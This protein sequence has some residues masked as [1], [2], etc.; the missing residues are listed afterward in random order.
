[1]GIKKDLEEGLA[2]FLVCVVGHVQS[3][4]LLF[5]PSQ[6]LNE[7]LGDFQLPGT[8][9]NA[10][11]YMHKRLHYHRLYVLESYVTNACRRIAFLLYP[12]VIKER[13]KY[14]VGRVE[15]SAA[16]AACERG[17]S[18]VNTCRPSFP[19]FDT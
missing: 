9:Y 17:H 14:N 18:Q 2:N 16:A 7:R 5:I 11:V 3:R 15:P 10:L 1:M 13:K 19:I 6:R 8:L 12:E 4:S